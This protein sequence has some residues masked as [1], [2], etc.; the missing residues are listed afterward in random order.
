MSFIDKEIRKG[1]GKWE[2][3]V[4]NALIQY[5]GKPFRKRKFT[6]AG[7]DY[8][9]DA[10]TP[11]SGP[12]H[13]GV[14]VKRI[15]AQRDIHKRIDEIINKAHHFK[16]TFPKS[17]FAAVIYFPFP[18]QHINVMNRLRS[19]DIN[20][21]VFAGESEQSIESAVRLLLDTIGATETTA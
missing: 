16:A 5:S 2:D 8:E 10:A 9:I 21:V 7:E 6:V 12:M 20:V 4:K 3:Q 1:K 18:Q 14:D 13:I 19:P 17:S 11:V 15:E